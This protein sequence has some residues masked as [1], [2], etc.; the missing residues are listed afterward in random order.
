L[1]SLRLPVPS[2]DEQVRIS[3]RYVAAQAR[4]HAE[5]ERAIKLHALKLGLMQYLLTGKVP[6]KL[7][8]AVPERAVA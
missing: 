4:I 8:E 2:V 6:V 5:S 1:K 3:D 7:P